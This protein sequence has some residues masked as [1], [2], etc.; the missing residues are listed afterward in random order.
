MIAS[1]PACDALLALQLIGVDQ[2]VQHHVAEHVDAVRNVIG[3]YAAV[4]AGRFFIRKGVEGAAAT[5]DGF[6]DLLRG[7]LLGALEEHVLDKVG[8]A[9]LV[10]ELV[11]AAGFTP[12]ADGGRLNVAHRF[13]EDADSILKGELLNFAHC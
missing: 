11:P 9:R 12:E 5:F 7:P 13:D 2:R 10:I 6:R 8:D 3:E 1:V 4:V